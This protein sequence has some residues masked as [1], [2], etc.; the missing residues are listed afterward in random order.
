MT[1]SIETLRTSARPMRTIVAGAGLAF[2]GIKRLASAIRHRRDVEALAGFDDRMLADIG[3]TRTDLHYALSEPFWR[4]PGRVLVL[5]AGERRAAP[6]SRGG[7]HKAR[8]VPA[9]SIV[10]ENATAQP[11]RC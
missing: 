11:A 8:A 5:R 1:W 6:R 4:D 10:P 7:Q 2:A 3:L 9:P